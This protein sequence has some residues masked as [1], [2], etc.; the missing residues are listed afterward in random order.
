MKINLCFIQISCASSFTS[1]RT[2]GRYF[3]RDVC[4]CCRANTKTVFSTHSLSVCTYLT[5]IIIIF[6]VKTNRE[7]A[8]FIIN[9]RRCVSE[10]VGGDEVHPSTATMLLKHFDKF[11]PH[12]TCSHCTSSLSL[13][14]LPLAAVNNKLSEI[15]M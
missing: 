5:Q 4:V 14:P 13:P 15:K 7:N 8:F 10:S 2:M 1:S 11:H 3:I 9:Y 12:L 6:V